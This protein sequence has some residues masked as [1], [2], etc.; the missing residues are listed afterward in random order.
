M[1]TIG[2]CV[3]CGQPGIKT[4]PLEGSLCETCD[5]QRAERARHMLAGILAAPRNAALEAERLTERLGRVVEQR[6]RL[7]EQRDEALSQRDDLLHAL[8]DCLAAM[9]FGANWNSDGRNP[10]WL[11]KARAAITRAKPAQ[12]DPIAGNTLPAGQPPLDND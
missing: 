10:E 12:P 3:D 4:M 2:P 7:I 9:P 5:A 8:T 11:K 6:D 1:I